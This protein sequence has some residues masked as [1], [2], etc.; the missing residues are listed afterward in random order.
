MNEQHDDFEDWPEAD[1]DLEAPAHNPG[2]LGVIGQFA[3][4]LLAVG[5][6]VAL[7]IAGAAALRWLF[8]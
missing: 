2:L 4:A 1:D 8:P 6:V 3:A 5:A 7:F